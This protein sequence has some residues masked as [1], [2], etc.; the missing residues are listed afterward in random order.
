M[1]QTIHC[2]YD[3]CDEPYD[4]MVS[5]QADGETTA[6]CDGHFLWFCETVV[7]AAAQSEADQAAAE[8]EAKLAAQHAAQLDAEPAVTVKRGTSRSRKA[9]E[10][11]RRTARDAKAE[12]VGAMLAGPD[13]DDDTDE[14]EAT[15]AAVR[16]IE[17]VDAD[18]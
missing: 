15:A 9:F 17:G 16:A 11:R 10:A 7:A 14:P 18:R 13:D 5:R 8:A 2:D 4:M 12:A 6:W 1:A 3:G